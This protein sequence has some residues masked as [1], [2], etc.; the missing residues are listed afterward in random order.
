ALE[1][2][3]QSRVTGAVDETSR[4]ETSGT[5]TGRVLNESGQPIAN[6]A[7]MIRAAAGQAGL[8]RTTTTR[9]DGNFQMNGLEPALYIVWTQVPAYTTP[10]S[11][12][13]GN[14]PN[15]YRVGDS[16]TLMLVKGGVITGSVTTAAADPVVR[17]GVR[18]L[19]IRDSSGKARKTALAYER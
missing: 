6:A 16:A 9:S 1:A 17:I 15:Y 13:D 5:I 10:S 12:P 2:S 19:L 7:V 11:D 8:P 18:A 4:A 3:A 14:Q